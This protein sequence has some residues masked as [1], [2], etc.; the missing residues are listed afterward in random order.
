LDST[1]TNRIRNSIDNIE[2]VS[3][4]FDV[5]KYIDNLIQP[6]K[7]ARE[8]RQK[9]EIEELINEIE[10]MLYD[11]NPH[12]YVQDKVAEFRR[13]FNATTDYTAL[14]T[15][16]DNYRTSLVD[17]A[18]GRATWSSTHTNRPDSYQ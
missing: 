5:E 8:T 2:S 3:N 7:R 11:F 13:R 15:E 18:L 1:K 4:Q 16:L 9:Q 17:R 10:R 6:F 14:H 12:E